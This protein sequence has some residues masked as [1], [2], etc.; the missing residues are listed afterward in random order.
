MLGWFLPDENG[1]V[2]RWLFNGLCLLHG[3]CMVD[4]V[5]ACLLHGQWMVSAWLVGGDWMV[6]VWLVHGLCGW[7]CMVGL[8]MVGVVGADQF[9]F[10]SSFFIGSF[11]MR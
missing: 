7:W 5:S 1:C 11:F 10:L 9:F 6:D 2:L 4:V 8:G 3:Q